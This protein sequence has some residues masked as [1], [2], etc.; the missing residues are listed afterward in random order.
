MKVLVTGFEPFGKLTVNP[1]WEA[2]KLLSE[3]PG[4]N[5]M[6]RKLLLPVEYEHSADILLET[7]SQFRPDVILCTGVAVK[8]NAVTP[9][10]VAVNMKDSSTPD[11]AG[12]VCIYEKIVDEGDSALYTNLPLTEALDAIHAAGV[13]ASPSF[14]AGTYVCNNLFYRLMYDIKYGAKKIYGG[15][16]HLPPESAVSARDA[17]R[18][19]E[20]VL[21][22]LADRPLQK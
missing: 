10:Y 9:E 18:A 19:I 11:N 4:K 20:A 21:L 13:P 1:S 2:V 12:K 7:A 5:I 16:V 3:R 14:D 15:F 22:M 17:A 6:L 8:R